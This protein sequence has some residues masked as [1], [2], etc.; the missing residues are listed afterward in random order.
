MTS[1]VTAAGREPASAAALRAGSSAART[2][3]THQPSSAGPRRS[4][5]DPG[6][7]ARCARCASRTGRGRR[8]CRARPRRQ[9]ASPWAARWSASIS[10]CVAS[11][12]RAECARYQAN[13]AVGV[14]A[15]GE[16]PVDEHDTVAVEA[17]VV[18]AQVAVDERRRP[19]GGEQ[20]VGE[21]VGSPH[22]VEHRVAD[23]GGDEL[24]EG[25]PT[26]LELLR[27]QVRVRALGVGDGGRRHA[28]AVA[29]R[30]GAGRT[31]RGTCGAAAR[32]PAGCGGCRR[33]TVGRRGR[34][35][36]R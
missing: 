4:R 12:R 11:M 18:A 20:C 36:G 13:S 15:R 10:S 25:V 9:P 32:R 35:A 26:L 27:Q 19:V 5:R 21:R 29:Q 17:E 22:E 7:R 28:D 14:P 33:G 34:A 6:A 31:R 1:M 2:R 23:V 30:R 8:P 3:G 16:V 24:G